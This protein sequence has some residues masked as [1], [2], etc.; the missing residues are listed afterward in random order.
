MQKGF[1]KV[2]ASDFRISNPEGEVEVGP[3]PPL[4]G[5]GGG[6]VTPEAMARL[7]EEGERT[8]TSTSY[9]VA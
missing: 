6:H 1:P 9:V 8:A 5:S 7:R 2:F 3:R 4:I